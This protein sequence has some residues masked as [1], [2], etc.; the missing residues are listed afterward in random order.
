M[1]YESLSYNKIY[2][3]SAVIATPIELLKGAVPAFRSV[4]AYRSLSASQ[5]T[6]PTPKDRF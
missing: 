4:W 1:L 2:I 5:V 6:T 3:H